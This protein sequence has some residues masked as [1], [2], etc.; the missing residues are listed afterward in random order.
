[1]RAHTVALLQNASPGLLTNKTNAVCP[2]IFRTQ[3]PDLRRRRIDFC[4]HSSYARMLLE[5]SAKNFPRDSWWAY[6]Y[7]DG[8]KK[9]SN[10]TAGIIP[11]GPGRRYTL[12]IYSTTTPTYQ[13][14]AMLLCTTFLEGVIAKTTVSVSP[15]RQNILSF[16][17]IT[18]HYYSASGKSRSLSH[19]HAPPYFYAPTLSAAATLPP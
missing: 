17:Q 16:A 6:F 1:M 10:Y 18:G 9:V 13:A 2:P 8:K 5:I 3:H 12:S 15:T 11:I 7:S 19:G 14:P 4:C